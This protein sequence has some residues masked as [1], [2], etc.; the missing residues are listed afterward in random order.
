MAM[1]SEMIMADEPRCVLQTSAFG[2]GFDTKAQNRKGTTGL[3]AH[4][5]S[6]AR[7]AGCIW[8]ALRAGASVISDDLRMSD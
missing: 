1:T 4:P 5:E 2:K 8:R 3:L 6:G 7:F